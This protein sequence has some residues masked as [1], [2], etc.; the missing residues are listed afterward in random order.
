MAENGV[1]CAGYIF[2]IVFG[3]T[4]QMFWNSS[5]FKL[6]FTSSQCVAKRFDLVG[7]VGVKSKN[8]CI[9]Y[10]AAMFPIVVFV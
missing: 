1:A 4:V 7:G 9:G 10:H 5:Q 3:L 2:C 6:L 8:P